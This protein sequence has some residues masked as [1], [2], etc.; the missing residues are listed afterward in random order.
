MFLCMKTHSF[1]SDIIELK[2]TQNQILSNEGVLFNNISTLGEV[3]DRIA[4]C[5]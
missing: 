4:G 3:N 5:F 2:K 1:L